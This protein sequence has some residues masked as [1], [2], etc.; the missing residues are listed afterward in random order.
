M[1]LQTIMDLFL[2]ELTPLS[3]A[4]IGGNEPQMQLDHPAYCVFIM[5]GKDKCLKL[6]ALGFPM[7]LMEAE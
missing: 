6:F 2:E 4:L 1:A 7:C 3:Q 5:I